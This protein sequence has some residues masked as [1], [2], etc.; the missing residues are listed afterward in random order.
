MKRL[1][2]CGIAALVLLL[3]VKFPARAQKQESEAQKLAESTGET[4]HGP[5]IF[6]G[7]AN[8]VLLAGG[9]GY[10]I[11]KNAGPYFAKRSLEIRKGM[12]EADAERAA[13]DAKVAEVDRRLANLQAEIEALRRGAQEE[14][15][16]DAQ[17]VRRDAAAEMTK[18]QS[19]LAEEIAS[20]VKSATLELR[21]Y[22][23]EAALGLAERKIAAR[24]S[25]AIQDRLVGSF[26][27]DM[28]HT[29]LSQ[30]G[31]IQNN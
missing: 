8:F 27:A 17:R 23:A 24:M 16:A 30:A 19:H 2:G 10:L 12:A 5:N 7:W 1:A 20:A 13:S 28:A 25:P 18:I 21:R 4:E 31:G 6:W 14:A 22:S 9:L 3:L 15:E 11:K 26:V 29:A